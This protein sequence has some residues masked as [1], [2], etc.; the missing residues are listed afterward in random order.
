M[1]NFPVRWKFPVRRSPQNFIDVK[2]VLFQIMVPKHYLSQCWP[3][4]TTPYGV[5]STQRV[6]FAQISVK[7]IE[8]QLQIIEFI[9][10]WQ[11]CEKYLDSLWPSDAMWRHMSILAQVMAC[12]LSALS[13]WLSKCWCFI[14]AVLWYSPGGNST[15]NAQDINHHNM[16]PR[17]QWINNRQ[18]NG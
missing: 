18:V 7:R 6:K 8:V 10:K 3:R 11:T 17:G 14:S 1:C 15:G 2:T 12:C 5:T 13:H 4:L 16:S 9:D